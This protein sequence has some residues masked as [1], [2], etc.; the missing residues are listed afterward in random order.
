[1]HKLQWLPITLR[2]LFQIL[3]MIL[4]LAISHASVTATQVI[5]GFVHLLYLVSRM[6]FLQVIMKLSPIL[7]AGFRL[8]GK[9]SLNTILLPLIFRIM[10]FHLLHSNFFTTGFKLFIWVSV[11]FLSPLLKFK[12]HDAWSYNYLAT[13]VSPELRTFL[14]HNKDLLKNKSISTVYV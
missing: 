10:L 4:L 9:P 11:Y 7:R 5:L 12:F 8:L 13:A 2:L 14:A 3:T 6:L 1:M